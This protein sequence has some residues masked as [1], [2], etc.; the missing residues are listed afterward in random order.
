MKK[1]LFVLYIIMVYAFMVSGCA[2][3]YN[4][5]GKELVD[6][7]AALHTELESADISVFDDESGN[8]VQKITYRF[9]GDVMQY[10][11]A[12]YDAE[13]GKT[14]LEYNNGTELNSKTLPDDSEWAFSTKG[15]ENYYNYSR[16]SRHYFADGAQLFNDYE[17]AVSETFVLH[18]EDGTTEL[19]IEYDL[20]KLSQYSTLAAYG[21]FSEFREI[22]SFDEN[23]R[24]R[25][26]SDVYTA[27]DGKRYSYTIK[28]SPRDEKIPIERTEE[29]SQFKLFAF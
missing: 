21:N 17:A 28:I 5:D 3:N 9:V 25:M 16:I 12:G 23:G 8:L 6:K 7:A 24:C 29:I 2:A 18:K 11:Y 1:I 10:M 15:D 22:Y 26:F 4:Y 20:T 27:E 13:S 14:Y 19:A